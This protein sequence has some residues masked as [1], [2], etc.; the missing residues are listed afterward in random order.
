[1]A[2]SG[3]GIGLIDFT[4]VRPADRANASIGA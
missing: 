1:M 3:S 2:V 4:S